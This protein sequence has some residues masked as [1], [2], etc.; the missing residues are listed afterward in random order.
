MLELSSATLSPDWDCFEDFLRIAW[1][2]P[3]TPASVQVTILD[4]RGHS[5]ATP[6]DGMQSGA[7]GDAVWDGESR[8]GRTLPIGPVIVRLEAVES[9][10]GHRVIVRRVV[11]IAGRL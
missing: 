5:L 9:G 3:F 2:L 10:T 4:P 7:R 8:D 1:N 11:V 6:V